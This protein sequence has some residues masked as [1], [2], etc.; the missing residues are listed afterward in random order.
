MANMVSGGDM[1]I[2]SWFDPPERHELCQCVGC[3]EE[4]G[5]DND[6]SAWDRLGC[7]LC[8]DELT[9]EAKRNVDF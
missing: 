8:Y 9:E 1:I 6:R 2:D 5:H 7:W 4:G 3:H